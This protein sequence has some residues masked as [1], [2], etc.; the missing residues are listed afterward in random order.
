MGLVRRDP[1]A[2]A[3]RAIA[4][5]L[6]N[7]WGPGSGATEHLGPPQGYP[8]PAWVRRAVTLAAAGA[9]VAVMALAIAGGALAPDW[10]PTL[11]VALLA[12]ELSAVR[13]E[14]R[15]VGKGCGSRR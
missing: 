2:Y 12:A 3:W 1:A 8:A 15:R 7:L 6:P 5:N 4:V 9:Y 11:L 10:R 14:E 13:S